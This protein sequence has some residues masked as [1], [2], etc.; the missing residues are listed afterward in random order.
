MYG[1]SPSEKDGTHASENDRVLAWT[2]DVAKS[3]A[4]EPPHP[5]SQASEPEV[6]YVERE[7]P[8]VIVNQVITTPA[9]VVTRTRPESRPKEEISTKAVIGTVLGATAGAVV[10]YG[11]S[12]HHVPF[13]VDNTDSENCNSAMTKAHTENR[14]IEPPSRIVHR[15]IEAPVTY[16]LV[17]RDNKSYACEYSGANSKHTYQAIAP[18]PLPPPHADDLMPRSEHLHH[19][20]NSITRYQVEG[21]T[22][23]PY[24]TKIKVSDSGKSKTTQSSFQEKTARQSDLI[25]I[26]EARSAK[27]VPIPGSHVTS[28]VMDGRE[29]SKL[30]QSSVLPKESISQVSTRRSG[31]SSRRKHHSSH[32]SRSG[33]DHDHSSRTSR[34]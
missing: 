8:K 19:S 3:T 5:T 21:A 11:T 34:K 27:D 6:R 25:P 22:C 1:D 17:Q 7:P 33:K 31:K 32:D 13:E 29:D 15:T 18:P 12:R 16:E 23:S 26:T 14:Y 20:S 2:K 10:A 28:L 4:V 30:G 24:V 9:V